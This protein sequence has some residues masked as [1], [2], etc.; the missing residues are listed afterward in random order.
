MSRSSK[1]EEWSWFEFQRKR[2]R[3]IN[4]YGLRFTVPLASLGSKR[5]NDR[6]ASP[7]E[8]QPGLSSRVRG[9]EVGLDDDRQMRDRSVL[10]L[11]LI[12]HYC[13]CNSVIGQTFLSTTKC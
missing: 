7:T 1:L 9:T 5:S 8:S 6:R 2:G 11:S 13:E 4:G 3:D 10:V 12:V